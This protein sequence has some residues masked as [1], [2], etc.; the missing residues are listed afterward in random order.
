MLIKIKSQSILEY[1][2]ILAAIVAV[3][4]TFGATTVRNAVQGM[5]SSGSQAMS[6]SSANLVDTV[7]GEEEE[8]HEVYLPIVIGR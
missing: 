6:A 7:G 2:I 5:F 8:E 3:I 4:A 1:L